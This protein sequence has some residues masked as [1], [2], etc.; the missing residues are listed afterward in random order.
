LDTGVTDIASIKQ[1]E[2][3]HLYRSWFKNTDKRI[4]KCIHDVRD[5][6]WQPIDVIDNNI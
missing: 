1:S 6:S 4:I 5:N 2:K 3:S